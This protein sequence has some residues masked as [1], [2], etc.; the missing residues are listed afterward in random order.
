[1]KTGEQSPGYIRVNIRRVLRKGLPG[2]W[3]NAFRQIPQDFQ[4]VSDFHI[5]DL[6]IKYEST[7]ESNKIVIG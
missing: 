6:L 2:D 3:I 4:C 5:R 7:A 1:L